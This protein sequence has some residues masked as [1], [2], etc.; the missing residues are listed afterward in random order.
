MFARPSIFVSGGCKLLSSIGQRVEASTVCR[1]DVT[2]MANIIAHS[3][4]IN[5]S[6]YSGGV[7]EG[8]R[9][10]HYGVV[11]LPPGFEF[12]VIARDFNVILVVIHTG[13][14]YPRVV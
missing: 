9:Y 6:E 12:Y 8:R 3:Y 11:I 2:Q 7:V 14:E 1:S 5:G 13:M 10:R 4:F